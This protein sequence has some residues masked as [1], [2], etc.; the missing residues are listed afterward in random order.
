MLA[1]PVLQTP[2]PELCSCMV[3]SLSC[4]VN[5]RI[6]AGQYGELFGEFCGYGARICDGIACSATTGKYGA[7]SVCTSKDK[8]SQEFNRYYESHK[9]KKQKKEE[10][11]V[12]FQRRGEDSVA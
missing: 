2:N 8:L 9:K 11:S 1:S 6:D 5:D 12:R 4:V 7:Y 3:C 10:V